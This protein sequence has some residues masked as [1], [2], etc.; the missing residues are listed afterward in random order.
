MGYQVGIDLGTTFTGAAVHRDGRVEVCPLGSRSADIPSVVLL[1]ED[2]TVLTGEAAVRRALSEPGRVAREFKRR[3]G[4]TTPIIV[5]GSPYSAEA[6]MARLL[7]SVVDEVTAREGAPPD[8]IAVS[9]P[10]NW[11]QYKIDLL[12]QAVVL[13]DLDPASVVF[14]TEPAA[15]ATFYAHQERVEP[16][17]IV[18]VY[19]LGGGTFDAAVLRAGD[20]GFEILGRPEGIERLGG[21]DFDAAVFSHVTRSLEGLFDD[22]DPEDPLAQNAVARLRLECVDAKEALSSDTDA[23]VPVLLPNAQTEVRITRAEFEALIRPALADSIASMRRALRSADVEAEDVSKVLLVGGSSRI[24][25]IAQLVSAELGR[26]VAVDTHPKH[27]ISMGAAYLAAGHAGVASD[28]AGLPPMIVEQTAV[29]D[30]PPVAIAPAQPAGFDPVPA[31]PAEPPVTAPMP[32]TPAP[33][34]STP[35]PAGGGDR[36]SRNL[37]YGGVAAVAV[38]LVVVG[39]WA[40]TGGGDDDGDVAPEEPVT[41]VEPDEPG[42]QPDVVEPEV[43]PPGE[44]PG[45]EDPGVDDPNP[46]GRPAAELVAD[47]ERSIDGLAVVPGQVMVSVAADDSGVVTL[48]G[49][50]DDEPIRAAVIGS[51]AAVDGVAGVTDLLAVR[52]PEERCSD[53]VRDRQ[54]WVC[55]VDAYVS[56]SEETLVA[57][58]VSDVGGEVLN[59]NGSFHYHVFGDQISIDDGGVPGIGPWLVWDDDDLDV[60]VTFVFG[61]TPVSDRL[62]MRIASA[63]HTIDVD[64]GNCRPI[65]R[66][67]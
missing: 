36:R 45:V 61:S 14:T 41:T 42:E 23:V 31:P 9:H 34:F 49:D 19:D 66:R 26:P 15:A 47:V 28:D 35:E 37:L 50:V 8:A 56:E 18:A 5:G 1:R 17:E 7:R 55:L 4:D 46:P 3:L 38:A 60:P 63:E 43:D 21:I 40:F 32:Q 6:L 44:E 57:S 65:E 59:V 27:A 20:A 12:H 64:S 62:C 30:P 58:Y 33:T 22:L 67:P 16:G 2:E 29:P 48:S 13:A 24:P 25:L 11:G 52:P 10:A 53:E 54:R 39:V 51:A